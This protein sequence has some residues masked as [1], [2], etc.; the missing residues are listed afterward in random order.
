MFKVVGLEYHSVEPA[1]MLQYIVLGANP[2]TL[3]KITKIRYFKFSVE[4]EGE[5]EREQE[6]EQHMDP[7]I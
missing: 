5:Q 1:I 7:Y 2:V 4:Y 3:P 6:R